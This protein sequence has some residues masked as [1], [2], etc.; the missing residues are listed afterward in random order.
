MADLLMTLFILPV[1]GFNALAG[2]YLIPFPV[3]KFISVSFHTGLGK[4][5]VK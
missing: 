4:L 2:F 1:L 3:C 5:Q